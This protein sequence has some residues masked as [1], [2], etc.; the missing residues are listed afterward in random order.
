MTSVR[1]T[2]TAIA[3]HWFLAAF[4]ICA[5]TIGL[6]VADMEPSPLRVRWIHYHKS[7]GIT[8]LA[9]SA[10]RLLWR[11]AHQPPT[12]PAAMPNWQQRAAVAA[13]WLLYVFFFAVPLVGWAYSCAAGFH[14][15]YLG[16]IPLPDLAP[17]DK[18]L[19]DLLHDAHETLAWGLATLVLLHVAAALKHQFVDKDGLIGRR[20]WR[21]R[22]T[23]R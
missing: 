22:A 6:S 19:A 23:A 12:L 8:I 4:L 21:A 18:A 17:K 7:I 13:H 3:L 20:V 16:L 14:V 5:F 10:F 11:L 15:V 9:L 2:S 1:Y